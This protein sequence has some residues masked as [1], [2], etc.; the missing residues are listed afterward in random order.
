[1]K[2]SIIDYDS[3]V[4]QLNSKK[5][6]DRVYVSLVSRPFS[7]KTII[8]YIYAICPG[9]LIIDI[10]IVSQLFKSYYHISF[11]G[12]LSLIEKVIQQMEEDSKHEMLL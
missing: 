5:S 6:F 12:K 1:M 3:V 2:F 11:G 4:K 9:E 8:K 10:Q 7:K